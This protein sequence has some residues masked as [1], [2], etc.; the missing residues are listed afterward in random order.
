MLIMNNIQLPN[1]LVHD[2]D[3]E[4]F[5]FEVTAEILFIK[6]MIF[7]PSTPKR[8]GRTCMNVII[9][10]L[11]EEEEAHLPTDSSQKTSLPP[12]LHNPCSP[13]ELTT[14]P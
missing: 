8:K 14:F 12:F 10:T 9:P 1:K 7:K 11:E 3:A 5:K 2:F 13:T 4:P 6:R